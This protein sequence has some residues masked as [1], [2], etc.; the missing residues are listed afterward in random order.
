MADLSKL[1]GLT[2]L[3]FF[4]TQNTDNFVEQLTGNSNLRS[5]EFSD[6]DLTDAGLAHV[7]RLSDLTDLKIEYSKR[8][9]TMAGL[10]KLE[11]LRVKTFRLASD[12]RHTSSQLRS[13][14]PDCKITTEVLPTEF[15]EN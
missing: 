1:E 7:A 11:R 12:T 4:Q 9:I 2:G 15:F 3:H 6:T 10:K 5:L 14:F 13:I 8:R